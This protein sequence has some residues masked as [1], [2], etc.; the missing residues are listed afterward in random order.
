MATIC[1]CV[2][3]ADGN[4]EGRE[5]GITSFRWDGNTLK[6]LSL[7]T[8]NLVVAMVVVVAID[9]IDYLEMMDERNQNMRTTSMNM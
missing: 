2:I 9:L 5:D 8:P 4:G 3:W 1:V 6:G 7:L